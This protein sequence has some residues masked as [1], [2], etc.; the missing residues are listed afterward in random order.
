MLLEHQHGPQSHG[1]LARSADVDTHFL[2]LLQNGVSLRA[3]PRNERAL[4]LA[5][6]ILDLARVLRPQTLEALVQI[7]ARDSGV[8]HQVPP[9]NFLD[10]RA[11]NDGA[12]GVAHPGIELAVWL[13]WSQGRV[14]EI[15]TRGLGLFGEGH[16]I[17]WRGEVPV[18]MGPELARSA[19]AGLHLVY[20]QEHVVAFRDVAETLEECWGG[21]VVAA[22]GLDRLDDDGGNGVVELLDQALGFLE[23]ALFLLGVFCGEILERVSQRRESGAGP[24][25]R[26]D[27][28]FV[29]GLAA[30]G[31]QTAKETAVE[32]GSER[33]DGEIRGPG[34]LV[35]HRG[36]QFLLGEFDL[37]PTTLL[38]GLVDKGS[39]VGGLV[40]V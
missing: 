10:D 33:H 12:S 14:A 5:S 9:F 18:L 25:E 4:A 28:E 34:P 2:A 27:I 39:L 32:A 36:R 23:T 1:T 6:E 38:H 30:G 16:H 29:D 37:G 22:L 20:D 35:R 31:G 7:V 3:V 11:G 8:L 19:D 21:V 15:V 26:R 24:V 13:V 17:R 40:G